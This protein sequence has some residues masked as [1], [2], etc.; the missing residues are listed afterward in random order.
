MPL[1][2]EKTAEDMQ[3]AFPSLII[4]SQLCS[5]MRDVAEH[6][7]NNANI[8]KKL[9]TTRKQILT[10]LSQ[11]IQSD[12]P[13]YATLQSYYSTE[14]TNV[15]QSK[16]C[17]DELESLIK[18]IETT[19]E[20]KE[21][22]SILLDN[23]KNM[24]TY[25]VSCERCLN[26]YESYVQTKSNLGKG[27]RLFDGFDLTIPVT[28]I[29][30]IESASEMHEP[31]ER[32]RLLKQS[33]KLLEAI[34]VN[35]LFTSTT[36]KY[37]TV[38][39]IYAN[40]DVKLNKRILAVFEESFPEKIK[41]SY[42][43]Y[44]T[45]QF[46]VSLITAILFS[47][48]AS[49]Q[50]KTLVP[51]FEES[52]AN[53]EEMTPDHPLVK[54]QLY[55]GEANNRIQRRF[56]QRKEYES[57]IHQQ[58]GENVA[59][60][61]QHLAQYTLNPSDEAMIRL[62]HKLTYI[63][64]ELHA[65]C[66]SK[67]NDTQPERMKE[68]IEQL[69]SDKIF[70]R[71]PIT[72]SQFINMLKLQESINQICLST[73]NEQ[74]KDILGVLTI[75]STTFFEEPRQESAN[76]GANISSITQPITVDKEQLQYQWQLSRVDSELSLHDDWHK[77]S[78][79]QWFR[80]T[81]FKHID[82][83][84]I[85]Y[86]NEELTLDDKKILLREIQH[87]AQRFID[88]STWFTR[89]SSV[90]SAQ[91]II[92]FCEKEMLTLQKDY[93]KSLYKQSGTDTPGTQ[94]WLAKDS[95]I[96]HIILLLSKIFNTLKPHISQKKLKYIPAINILTSYLG[97]PNPSSNASVLSDI[98]SLSIH[99]ALS[100]QGQERISS[101]V[102]I[103]ESA[104]NQL[105]INKLSKKTSESLQ[106]AKLINQA[107]RLIATIGNKAQELP[108]K[109][110]TYM[111]QPVDKLAT[112]LSKTTNDFIEF[113]KLEDVRN[114]LDILIKHINLEN[115]E[116]IK[117]IMERIDS[118]IV[119]AEALGT[120][121]LHQQL[122]S[123]KTKQQPLSQSIYAELSAEID[124]QVSLLVNYASDA[125]SFGIWGSRQK[126]QDYSKFLE[127]A[128][129]LSYTSFSISNFF[130]RQA[131]IYNQV[132]S[133]HE[134]LLDDYIET[135]KMINKF[136]DVSYLSTV[137]PNLVRFFQSSQLK[138]IKEIQSLMQSIQG[139]VDLEQLNGFDAIS[140]FTKNQAT[141][142]E[143]SRKLKKF[144][145]SM[146]SE[147]HGLILANSTTAVKVL[148]NE[149]AMKNAMNHQQIQDMRKSLMY[150]SNH[151]DNVQKHTMY[152]NVVLTCL[153]HMIRD[154]QLV[155]SINDFKL[156]DAVLTL[157]ELR[158]NPS[159]LMH[160]NQ[161]VD[162]VKIITERLNHAIAKASPDFLTK[163]QHSQLA[164]LKTPQNVQEARM[165]IGKY[166]I[167]LDQAITHQQ[168][169]ATLLSSYDHMYQRNTRGILKTAAQ[170][171]AEDHQYAS[172][173][174]I[175]VKA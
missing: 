137:A 96:N 119:E 47:M 152:T 99:E 66:V 7:K 1:I 50:E 40:Q 82:A 52:F 130:N 38:E 65:Y 62:I 70:S 158:D 114:Q 5:I 133:G 12:D 76:A 57:N 16:K 151:L 67:F 11:I 144:I 164:Q 149:V 61:M 113:G 44:G 53:G 155:K 163:E 108:S 77:H 8:L 128:H 140:H 43:V 72:H 168:N 101:F 37:L 60:C 27:S 98:M 94:T 42:S 131:L 9:N 30:L 28:I 81:Q 117:D 14:I 80:P 143:A 127:Q 170:E 138:S 20:S 156:F 165:V 59:S 4:K 56:N 107:K 54:T 150:F 39:D 26:V 124:I 129:L 35:A 22:L 118:L 145:T 110:P 171:C 45:R 166:M 33:I 93:K 95:D 34:V 46:H 91:K 64:K 83:L 55:F 6:A 69:L 18:K 172:G 21:G 121:N 123:I 24:V 142:S 48:I 3:R 15:E 17:A 141:V 160:E 159:Q 105:Q 174:P 87:K 161:I 79:T 109:Y 49:L 32:D 97:F 31:K 63:T 88:Q 104:L 103:V 10:Q 134:T 122:K 135:M 73:Q 106:V 68:I 147:Q 85:Q 173:I 25:S 19:P 148:K 120:V 139:G 115:N 132:I 86:K 162:Q 111:K 169:N 112:S 84:I 2:D 154:L 89:K 126:K 51:R 23:Y 116:D 36:G 92:H 13:L 153:D 157:K 100:V 146:F 125:V 29:S 74:M 175:Y 75:C 167:I 136:C 78:H 58:L 41:K 90:H 102:H 71:V